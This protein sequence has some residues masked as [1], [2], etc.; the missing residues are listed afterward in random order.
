MS[1]GIGEWKERCKM[2][3]KEMTMDDKGRSTAESFTVRLTEPMLY[4]RLYSL[5]KEYSIAVELLVDVAVR[6]LL[7]DVEFVRGLRAGKIGS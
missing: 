3:E 7:D 4:D 2:A 5:S 6:R 1:E